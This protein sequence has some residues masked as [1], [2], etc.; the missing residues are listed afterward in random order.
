MAKVELKNDGER[1]IPEFH[2]NDL[3]YAEHTTRYISA[4]EVCK[5]KVVLD[6]ASGSG[7]GSRLLADT[8][9]MVYGVEIDIDSVNYA[10]ENFSSPNIEF[11]QGS[12]TDIP[13]P[14]SSV[15]V[16][17]T[18]ET[19]EHIKD[20]RRFMSEI[21]RVLKKGGIAIISTPND[22][23]FAE[24][25]HFH[26]HE[27]EYEE[28]K[29]L[30][31]EQFTHT[32]EYFQ[33]TWKAAVL[34]DKTLLSKEGVVT[35][36][37]YNQAGLT[38]DQFLYF[39]F[40]CSDEKIDTEIK[41]IAALGEHYS[42]RQVVADFHHN[43]MVIDERNRVIADKDRELNAVHT[44]TDQLQAEIDRLRGQVDNYENQLKK[45]HQSKAYKLTRKIAHMTSLKRVK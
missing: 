5:G 26:L 36:P 45:I 12:A 16:V 4:Q 21:K 20:Y 22:I 15:D 23:E 33:A 38:V 44:H 40:L 18:F 41:P 13:L 2:K 11:K 29:K 32:K 24:G 17:V 10:K 7:Y 14:D 43:N 27:F 19:I 8:A 34:G 39:Y 25:N 28:F 9:E 1:M 6:I 31:N 37:I 3:V 35:L 30:V 42:H